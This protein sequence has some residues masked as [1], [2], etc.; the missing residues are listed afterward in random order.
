[1]KTAVHIARILVG[2]LFVLSG[3]I[4]A[5]DPL[6][7]GYKMLEFF[8]VW[9][10]SLTA[11]HFFLKTLLLTIIHAGGAHAL[12]LSVAMIVLEIMAGVA[13]LLGWQKKAVLWLLLLLILFFTF[14]TGFAY[15]SGKFKNCGCF[16]D[17]LPITPLTSFAKDVALTALIVFLFFFQRHIRPFG[18]RRFQTLVLL[19]TLV[20]SLGLQ[21]YV[22]RYLPLADCLPYKIGANIAAGMKP[23]S[24]AVPDSIAIIF[25]YEKGGKNFEFSAQNLPADLAS[26]TFKERRDKLVRKGNADAAIHGF[27][28][29]GV[30]DIDSTSFVLQ[31]PQAILYFYETES[32]VDAAVQENLRA[33]TAAAAQKNIPVFVLTTSLKTVAAAF[34]PKPNLYFFKI[35]FTAFRTAARTNPCIYFLQQGTIIDKQSIHRTHHIL[36]NL[37]PA[38]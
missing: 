28:L 25:V 23:P 8:D 10:E 18:N 7:L 12:A 9:T 13:L 5:N 32:D 24:N 30:S 4:K 22:L 3:L 11:G 29:S 26:Y 36:A 38:R 19:L 14:L 6:G 17:C 1:M 21:G 35:D 16:G 20:L 27:A 15:A 37:K 2:V 31:Q 33:V 34:A